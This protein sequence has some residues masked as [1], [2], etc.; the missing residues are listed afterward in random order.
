MVAINKSSVNERLKLGPMWTTDDILREQLGGVDWVR[1]LLRLANPPL[2][3][4]RLVSIEV[5]A[6]QW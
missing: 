2:D 6:S 4:R 3:S 5:M 1:L